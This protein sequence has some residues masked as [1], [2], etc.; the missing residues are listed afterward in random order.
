MATLKNVGGGFGQEGRGQIRS[1]TGNGRESY[2][3]FT[4]FKGVYTYLQ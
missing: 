4:G 2:Y 1:Q 3:V